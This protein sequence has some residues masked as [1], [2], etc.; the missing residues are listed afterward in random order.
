MFPV[1]VEAL[2]Y[3]RIKEINDNFGTVVNKFFEEH[4]NREV[5]TMIIFGTPKTGQLIYILS[6][7]AP[8][9]RFTQTKWSLIQ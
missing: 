5:S 9:C 1:L 8:D 7:H 3:C 2:L 6:R 4:V